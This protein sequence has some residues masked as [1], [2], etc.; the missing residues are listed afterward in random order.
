MMKRVLTI[1][2][3]ASSLAFTA[4]AQDLHFSQFYENSVLTNPALTG[5][6]SG[7]YKVGLDYRNQWASVAT[8]FSTTMFS[9]ETKILVSHAVADYISFGFGGYY[10]QAGQ[11]SFTSM[12]VYPSIAY[13]KAL[14]DAHNTYLSVGFT[15]GFI[16][17]YVDQSKM[18]F[19]NQ[20]IPGV[21][22]GNGYSASNPTG[23]TNTYR[24][25]S[26]YDVG[27]GI[28]LNG[29]F[30]L[31]NKAN[32]Y[33][34]VGMYHLNHPTEVFNISNEQM[35]KLP[36]R[37][38]YSAGL[39]LVANEHISFSFHGEYTLQN[40]YSEFIG[41]GLVTF[42][43]VPPG[44]PSIFALSLGCFV[45]SKDAV[46]PTVK[47]DYENVS[48]GFSYD[49]TTSTLSTGASGASSAE[50]TLYVHG[51]YKHRK[52]PVD[53]IRCPRFDDEIYYPF[54]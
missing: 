39:H 51:M 50:L 45:R 27:A 24:S 23:E 34:G 6:F 14:E 43:S 40:P 18:T 37:S 7:D 22:P 30:D 41:G 10:D 21:G 8:P 16:G 19:S 9:A 54:H 42:R 53:P 52:D 36:I 47:I 38:E 33:L 5:V 25:L 26:N 17:R 44:M 3:L 35:A 32:Y 11:I 2:S 46:I 28:A 4:G 31:E 49:V 1:V 20:W 12:E 48:V 29:S 15:G 13:N